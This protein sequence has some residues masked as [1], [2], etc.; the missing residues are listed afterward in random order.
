MTQPKTAKHTPGSLTV[1]NAP[2]QVDSQGTRVYRVL[3]PDG[4]YTRLVGEFYSLADAQLYAKAPQTYEAVLDVLQAAL[5]YCE[6]MDKHQATNL[7]IDSRPPIKK[8][9]AVLK[10]IQ[11]V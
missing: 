8:L 9:R 7:G 10:L 1:L 2:H 4:K 6:F 5:A 11:E 3:A